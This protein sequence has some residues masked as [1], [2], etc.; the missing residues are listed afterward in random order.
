MYIIIS[1]KENSQL[2]FNFDQLTN[3]PINQL[4]YLQTIKFLHICYQHIKV[5]HSIENRKFVAQF[6]FLPIN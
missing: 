6:Q 4:E 5:H 1:K 2:N 3:Q